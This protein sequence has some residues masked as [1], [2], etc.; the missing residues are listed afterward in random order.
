MSHLVKIISLWMFQWMK[1]DELF[2]QERN[3]R[4]AMSNRMGVLG[5]M[6]HQTIDH[7]PMT[8]MAPMKA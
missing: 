4:L 1:L 3:I 2:E 7:D 6:L 8:P 5:L